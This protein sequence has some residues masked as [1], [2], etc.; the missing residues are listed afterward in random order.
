MKIVVALG[1]NALTSKKGKSDY[2]ST[3]DS[4]K[5]ISIILADL[6]KK[7]HN[8]VITQDKNNSKFEF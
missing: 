1:G 6:V 4:L 8:L 7:K 2:K 3:L 5:K